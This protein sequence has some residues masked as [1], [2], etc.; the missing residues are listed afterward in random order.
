METWFE[1]TE[2]LFGKEKLEILKRSHVLVMGLGGVGGFA[3]EMIARAGVGTMTIVDGDTVARSNRNRQLVALESTEGKLKSEV[4]AERLRSVN[5]D[6]NL[7]VRSEYMRDERMQELIDAHDYD[8]VVDCIDTLAPKVFLIQRALERG[9]RIVSSMGAG[10]KTNP[11][12]ASVA[13]LSQSY[14]CP[15][16]RYVRKRL[17][18]FGIRTGFPVVFSSELGDKSKVVVEQGVNKASTVGTVSFMPAVFGIHCASVVIR[19]LT[20][21]Q[22][23]FKKVKK[24]KKKSSKKKGGDKA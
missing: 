9:L 11:A 15:L 5:P 2:L 20:G 19:Q 4:L 22:N 6:I 18:K 3:A 10:N 8:F 16:A 12:L 7:H 17:Q 21:E 23:Y 14:N 24:K 1:R 13:D